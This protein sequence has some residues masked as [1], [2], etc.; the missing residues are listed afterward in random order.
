MAVLVQPVTGRGAWNKRGVGGTLS[1][2]GTAPGEFYRAPAGAS[3]MIG[4]ATARKVKAAQPVDTNEYATWRAVYA[5][6]VEIQV[7]LDGVFGNDTAQGLKEWQGRVGLKPDGI[8]GQASSKWMFQRYLQGAAGN[9]SKPHHD[10]YRAANGH[11]WSESSMDPGCVGTSTPEDLGLCQ[12]NG[13]WHPDLSA[14]FRLAPRVALPWQ[15]QFVQDNI[16]A[17]GGNIGDGIAA[18]MLGVGGTKQWVVAGRPDVWVRFVSTGGITQ[19]IS[20]PVRA[21]IDNVWKNGLL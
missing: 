15:V 12:I 14:D 7:E 21:Y 10:L 1:L 17:M 2:D 16:D 11:T 5:I 3:K 19:R 6:Q 8:F 13:R 20:T 4:A 18:Y 9:V